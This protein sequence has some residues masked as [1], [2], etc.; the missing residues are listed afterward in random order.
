MNISED[1]YLASV[2]DLMVGLLF[3]FAIILMAYALNYRLAADE[4]QEQAQ[5]QQ[6]QQAL[7][8]AETLAQQ[9]EKQRLILEKQHLE[10]VVERLTNNETVRRVL[11][12]E[13]QD[14][15]KKRGL[16]VFIDETQGVLRLPESLLFD[17][18]K[19]D[20][21]LE[22]RRAIERL[23]MVLL[24][25]LPCYS[26]SSQTNTHCSSGQEA[27]LEA[28]LIEGHTDRTPIHNADFKDNW[29]LASARAL[30]TYQTLIAYAPQ[31]DELKNTQQQALLSVSAYEARR[32]VELSDDLTEQ[33]K[34]RRID[35]RFLMAS[36]PPALIEN[37]KHKIQNP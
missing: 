4:N 3:I 12:K 14:L 35:L 2:S 34:N 5:Q 20:F 24:E 8:V 32:P 23:A 16:T 6:R 25:I 15:L 18:G 1:N 17:S 9:Q 22:G 19:A 27:R 33:R 31:L 37:A 10:Q 21:R 7:L 11:L 36:P 28:V 30:N 26:A 13:I 29:N